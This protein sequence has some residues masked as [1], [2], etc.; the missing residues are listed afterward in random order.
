MGEICQ[1]FISETGNSRSIAGG[2]TGRGVVFGN[3]IRKPDN[4]GRVCVWSSSCEGHSTEGERNMDGDLP[5]KKI[6]RREA[7]EKKEDLPAFTDLQFTVSYRS[8]FF[9]I[10]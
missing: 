9:S 2:I 8:F 5:L 4:L 1:P 10:H 3:Q 7:G 6:E